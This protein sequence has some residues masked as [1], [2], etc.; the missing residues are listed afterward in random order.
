MQ[1]RLGRRRGG[2]MPAMVVAARRSASSTHAA[3]TFNVVAP[4]LPW[5][6]RPGNGPHVHTGSDE[7]CRRVMAQRMQPGAAQAEL[8]CEPTVPVTQ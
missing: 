4:P 3:Y 5:P 1:R 7:L 8:Q 6:R 2:M